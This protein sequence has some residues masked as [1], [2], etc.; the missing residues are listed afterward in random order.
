MDKKYVFPELAEKCFTLID[1]SS[2]YPPGV[3]YINLVHESVDMTHEKRQHIYD[4]FENDLIIDLL[5]FSE[6]CSV[7]TMPRELWTDS[8]KRMNKIKD[9]CSKVNLQY[10]NIICICS[11]QVFGDIDKS[12]CTTI[13]TNNPLVANKIIVINKSQL[14]ILFCNHSRKEV[15]TFIKSNSVP[16]IINLNQ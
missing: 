1:S 16:F 2:P 10:E 7:V 3:Q 5:G 12:S 4:V 6:H 11:P 9:F 13:V 15:T 8:I 14:P